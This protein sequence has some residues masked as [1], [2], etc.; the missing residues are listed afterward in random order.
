MPKPARTLAA[1]GDEDLQRAGIVEW[2]ERHFAKLGDSVADRIADQHRLR[3]ERGFQPL[4]LV[5]SGGDCG[6]FP[7]K[8]AIDPPEHRILLV[9]QRRYPPRACGQQRRKRGIA[10]KADHRLRGMIT[11]DRFRLAPPGEHRERPPGPAYR[12]TAKPSGREHVHRHLVEQ[13]RNLGPAR[14]GDQHHAVTA[15]LE[16]GA[17]RMGRD[18]V[19]A[20]PTGSEHEVHSGTQSPLHFTT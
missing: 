14:I 16:L 5:I 8:Q 7:R 19:A 10:A 9:K 15:G 20:G 17:K 18:H 12:A 3:L 1:A 13:A 2:R 4:D 6:C 11:V